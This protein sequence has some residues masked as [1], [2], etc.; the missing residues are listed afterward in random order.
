MAA[1]KK[2]TKKAAKAIVNNAF[3]KVAFGKVIPI[4]KLGAVLGAGEKALEACAAFHLPLTEAEMVST[5]EAAIAKAVAE[6]AVA[7]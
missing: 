5:V 7:A 1:K 4:M 6:H 3:A 2:L